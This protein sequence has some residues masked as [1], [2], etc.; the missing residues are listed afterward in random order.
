MLNPVQL[1]Q[2]VS[3]C[4]SPIIAMWMSNILIV[5]DRNNVDHN[6]ITDL[7]A[8]VKETG[9]DVVNV[10]EHNLVIEADLPTHEVVTVAAM[11]GVSYVRNVFSYFKDSTPQEAA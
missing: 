7:A 11:D 3:A 2:S 4:P 6:T 10:D 5:V 9:A 1:V 8:A